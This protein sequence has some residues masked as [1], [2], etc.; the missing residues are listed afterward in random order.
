MSGNKAHWM[1]VCIAFLSAALAAGKA[2]AIVWKCG[3]PEQGCT[4]ISCLPPNGD[5]PNGTAVD[6]YD[7]Q[8]LT[9]SA[10]GQGNGISCGDTK[11][12]VIVCTESG[13]MKSATKNCATVIC[14]QFSWNLACP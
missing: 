3:V 4:P 6:F 9:Y 2:Y 7:V 11:R 13:Y 1:V 10:C 14:Q 5:C 12:N 8:P